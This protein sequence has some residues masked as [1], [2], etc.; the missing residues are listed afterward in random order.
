MGPEFA[1]D[2]LK[3]LGGANNF[4]NIEVN[5]HKQATIIVHVLDDKLVKPKESEDYAIVGSDHVY[6]VKLPKKKDKAS[7]SKKES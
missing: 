6:D 5:T 4:A 1:T 3:R 7:S 2:I